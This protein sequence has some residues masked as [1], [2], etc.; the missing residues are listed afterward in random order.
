MNN[1]SGSFKKWFT[2][3]MLSPGMIFSSVY[4]VV[5]LS[6]NH[7]LDHTFKLHLK[8]FFISETGLRCQLDIGSLR[9]GL[10]LNSITL[11]NIELTFPGDHVNQGSLPAVKQ[12]AKLRIDCPD[13]GFFPFRLADET[14][15]MHLVTS[16]I[17]STPAQ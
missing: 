2:A 15:S 1:E 5:W 4:L 9:P 17:L 16:K 8:R 10:D 13:L 3:L 11:E 12:I 7:Y 6:A 14:C